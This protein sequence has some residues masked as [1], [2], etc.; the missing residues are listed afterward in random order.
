MK[1]LLMSDYVKRPDIQEKEKPL[2]KIARFAESDEGLAILFI[3][4]ISL[5]FGII[6]HILSIFIQGSWK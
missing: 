5:S 3:L 1:V 2:A 4:A 6:M